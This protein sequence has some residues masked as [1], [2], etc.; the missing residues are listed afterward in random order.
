MRRRPPVCLGYVLPQGYWNLVSEEL[1]SVLPF[2]FLGDE[3]ES[4][5]KSLGAWRVS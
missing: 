1:K 3:K 5:P 4:I 2:S